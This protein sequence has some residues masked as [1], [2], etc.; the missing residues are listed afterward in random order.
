MANIK[1]STL[2]SA[3][4]FSGGE[5]VPILQG[6]LNKQADVGV[7]GG[8]ARQDD[9]DNLVISSNLTLNVPSEFSDI[10]LALDSI[11]DK[12]IAT[13]ATVTIDVIAGTHSYTSAVNTN[14]TNG[15]RIIVRGA[16]PVVKTI[17]SVGAITGNAGNWSVPITLSNVTGVAINDYA[18]L[19]NL[20]GT[21]AY[22]L[23][24]SVWKITNIV[25]NTITVTNTNQN[26]TFDANTLTGG[27]CT[28]VKTILKFTSANGIE[29]G[30]III[31]DMII[32]CDNLYTCIL[33]NQGIIQCTG[34]VGVSG[35]FYGVYAKDIGSISFIG[36]YAANCVIGVAASSFDFNSGVVRATNSNIS[37]C[38][39]GVYCGG[40]GTTALK[41][42]KIYGCNIGVNVESGNVS[43]SNLNAE[44][45]KSYG[46]VSGFRGATYIP[47][48]TVENNLINDYFAYKRGYIEATGYVGVPSFSPQKNV[49]GNNQGYITG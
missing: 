45:N 7:T 24:N 20:T 38:P 28:V 40:G 47:N 43:A 41:S 44:Y 26:I 13:N 27:F 39:T 22:K 30:S 46:V 1:F 19:S 14:H 5:T 2:P 36:Q 49:V 48:S 23:H 12:K 21:G 17:I 35:G 37:G 11:A 33:C 32:I 25:S 8:F 34:T 15:D 31:Q 18:C 3:D 16:T 29:G 4:P 6:G 10:Q 9:L 42:S